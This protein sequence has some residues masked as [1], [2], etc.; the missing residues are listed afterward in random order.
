VHSGPQ[1]GS[2]WKRDRK[3]TG[4]DALL[5]A[6]RTGVVKHIVAYHPDRLM[7]RP[8]DLEQLL[9]IAD[10][11]D[12]MLHGQANRRDLSDADNRFFLRIEVA[13]AC[14]SSDDTSRRLKAAM[15]DQANDGK[16]HSGRRRN[17]YDKDAVTQIPAEA[18]IVR[19]IF[20]RY[21]DGDS[22]RTI[23][24][25]L[26]TREVPTMTEKKWET[27]RVMAVLDS[28]HVAG[29]RVFH[30]EEIGRGT[31]EPIIDEGTFAEAR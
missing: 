5:D 18:Q 13:H 10:D 27:W 23:A 16:P 14:R 26:N 30:E 11:A 20:A 12:I 28:R 9:T 6:A 2:A 24:A 3:R 4:W 25:D 21:L 22:P 15:I 8:K 1:D 31:W 17:G 29:I 19:E 7:R